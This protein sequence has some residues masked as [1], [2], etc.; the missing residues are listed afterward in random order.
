MVCDLYDFEDLEEKDWLLDQIINY[1][2]TKLFLEQPRLKK[3]LLTTFS[4]KPYELWT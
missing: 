1:L 4:P 2:V 3:A